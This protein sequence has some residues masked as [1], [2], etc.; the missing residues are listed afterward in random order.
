MK[1]GLE[2]QYRKAIGLQVRYQLNKQQISQA[3]AGR[4]AGI[5]SS[6]VSY[7]LRGLSCYTIDTLTKFV[8]G[9]NLNVNL[10]SS[11]F[12]TFELL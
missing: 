3:E 10:R 1:E 4:R 9:N 8:V 7:I 5:T 12:K 2:I 11:F 6:Q